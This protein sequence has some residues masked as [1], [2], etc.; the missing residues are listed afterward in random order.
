MKIAVLVVIVAAVAFAAFP[1]PAVGASEATIVVVSDPPQITAK[2]F[3]DFFY[4][5]NRLMV[6]WWNTGGRERVRGNWEVLVGTDA[7]TNAA[8]AANGRRGSVYSI[9]I[10]AVHREEGS[11]PLMVAKVTPAEQT[12]P[13]VAAQ[14]AAKRTKNVLTGRERAR[15]TVK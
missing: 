12:Y 1:A 10:V 7:S 11:R 8:L 6:E 14:K 2:P 9:L 4:H 15:R 13:L 3:M 5:Y